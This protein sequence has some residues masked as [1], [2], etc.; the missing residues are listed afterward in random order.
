MGEIEYEIL[1]ERETIYG[2]ELCIKELVLMVETETGDAT[3]FL[4]TCSCQQGFC[5]LPM[6]LFRFCTCPVVNF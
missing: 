3:P 1:G 6:V 4:G 2:I 5:Y